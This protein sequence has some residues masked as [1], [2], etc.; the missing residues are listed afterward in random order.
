M[1]ARAILIAAMFL[2][3]MPG[4]A[5]AQTGDRPLERI[6]LL[7]TRFSGEE[8]SSQS[9]T[10]LFRLQVSA[11][12]REEGT[13]TRANLVWSDDPLSP[14]THEAAVAFVADKRMLF[15][16]VLWGDAY[17]LQDG[18]VLQP[19]VS[20]TDFYFRRNGPGQFPPGIWVISVPTAGA[21]ERKIALGLPRAF[22]K[23]PLVIY[24]PESINPY[25]S[26]DGLPIYKDRDFKVA[27]GVTGREFRALTYT[28][29]AVLLTSGGVKGW[30]KLDYL[31]E[32]N[33][34]AVQF[35]SAL[36]RVT[37]GDYS[38]AEQ[39]LQEVRKSSLDLEMKVNTELL[40]GL[41]AELRGE[42][43]VEY[44]R[45]A[46]QK[47][48]FDASVIRYLLAGWITEVGRNGVNSESAVSLARVFDAK[49]QL[50]NPDSPWF[51]AVSQYLS[52]IR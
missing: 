11:T 5:K 35:T 49:R 29:S 33:N 32:E 28:A 19:Y 24:R 36:V 13:D 25:P 48:P 4:A 23:L 45:Q 42:S 6:F 37:R 22:F 38:G 27:V 26:L 1:I 41:C 10:N 15:H 7:S 50:F 39:L 3:V 47:A 16:L 43:G 21:E 20:V 30:V 40:L 34:V 17:T 2:V 52:S 9:L 31:N 46:A 44:F 8:N 12:F 18:I 51:A 14:S